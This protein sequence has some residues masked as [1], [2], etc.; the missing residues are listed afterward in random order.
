MDLIRYWDIIP[1]NPKLEWKTRK[2][3]AVKRIVVHQLASPIYPNSTKD[4]DNNIKYFLSDNN[5]ITPGKALPYIPY[6]VVID[7]D[8]KVY[9]CNEFTYETWHCKGHNR[10]SV[11]I[12][13]MGSFDGP[14]F[15]GRDKEPTEPQIN[16]L[17]SVLNGFIMYTFNTITKKD[18][19]GHCELDPTRKAACPGN[20]IMKTLKEWRLVA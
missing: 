12:A 19:Y 16:S 6:H 7:D 13:L 5:H 20:V 3:E 17:I 15:K 9:W 18:V 8:G 10:D 2:L 11:G 14:G 1:H 4:I